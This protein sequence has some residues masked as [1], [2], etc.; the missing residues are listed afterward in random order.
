M[1][2]TKKYDVTLSF[3]GEL[4][5][6]GVEAS[7]EEEAERIAKDLA[8]EFYLVDL[9]DSSFRS[10]T[11]LFIDCFSLEFENDNVTEA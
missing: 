3:S 6:N 9:D 1:S 4:T 7:S 5:I 8:E 2:E 11:D 10:E